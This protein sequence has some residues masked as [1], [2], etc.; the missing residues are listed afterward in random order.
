MKSLERAVEPQ[1]TPSENTAERNRFSDC[2]DA[3]AEE[4]V[5]DY[6]ILRVAF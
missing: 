2:V 5:R 4:V 6:T 1:K 3:N